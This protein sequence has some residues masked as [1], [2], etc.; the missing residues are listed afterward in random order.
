MQDKVTQLL[1]DAG[2]SD[3]KPVN[4]ISTGSLAGAAGSQNSQAT[5][6]I[7]QATEQIQAL[8]EVTQT[9]IDSIT[10]NTDALTDTSQSSPSV[11]EQVAVSLSDAAGNLL[12]GGLLGGSSGGLS[13]LLGGGLLGDG[14]GALFS[15]ISS[16]F[17][18]GSSH[19]PPL[20]QYT[21]PDKQDFELA[22]ADGSVSDSVQDSY[23]QPRPASFTE[24]A[25]S[26]LQPTAQTGSSGSSGGSSNSQAPSNQGTQITVQVQAMDSQSFMDRSGDI[27][28]A[29]R[30]AML[31]MHSINDVVNDL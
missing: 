9:N 29:V 17:G 20:T 19:P 28:Q 31:N 18:G 22:D 11:G 3:S 15:G 8:K 4:S 30:Q 21:A 24:L 2:L 16:L 10:A 25:M 6:S 14:I 5:D 13:G 12:G 26:G 23:G 7:Q 27:A 1:K